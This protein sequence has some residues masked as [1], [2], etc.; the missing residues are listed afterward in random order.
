MTSR[1]DRSAW[2]DAELEQARERLER[3]R[4]RLLE[5]VYG[6]RGP[7]DD[8]GLTATHVVLGLERG[9]SAAL[10]SR[11]RSALEATN[12]ALRRLDEGSYG[13]CV[14]CG[15]PIGRERLEAMPE[16]AWCV[17]CQSRREQER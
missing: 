13:N 9:I 1:I 5:R 12:A 3:Q 4:R 7:D 8:G 16:T 15:E 10:D 11:L 14:S 17:R 2:T 6:W